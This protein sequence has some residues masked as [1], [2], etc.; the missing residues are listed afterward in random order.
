M[1]DSCLPYDAKLTTGPEAESNPK[2][3]KL[4]PARFTVAARVFFYQCSQSTFWSPHVWHCDQLALP[5]SHLART[6]FPISSD[7]YLF[8]DLYKKVKNEN[9]LPAQVIRTFSMILK[10]SF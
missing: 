6:Y 7:L 8:V 1:W 5:L 4:P 2:P 3:I 10:L 9:C